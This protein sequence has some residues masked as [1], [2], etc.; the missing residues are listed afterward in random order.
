MSKHLKFVH[1]NFLINILLNEHHLVFLITYFLSLVIF[2]TM[3][4]SKC[5]N[6][7]K[8]PHPECDYQGTKF[9]L[10]QHFGRYPK[11]HKFFTMDIKT[12]VKKA[13]FTSYKSKLSFVKE[14]V[15]TSICN[16]SNDKISKME[17]YF[18]DD[19]FGNMVASDGH[20]NN[21]EL[22]NNDFLEQSN[23][24][25]GSNDNNDMIITNN[26]N[27]EKL[28]NTIPHQH[29]QRND[30]HCSPPLKY[31][32]LNDD[33]PSL[34]Y[35]QFCYLKSDVHELKLLQIL[36]VDNV[37]HDLHKDIVDWAR[38]AYNDGYKFNPK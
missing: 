4:R 13:A 14:Q 23:D 8:C 12:S 11:C 19:G 33:N 2:V 20:G 15:I 32:F 29:N 30:N 31:T 3:M 21:L 28:I 7:L 22:L 27:E 26:T 37:P 10:Q 36:S 18:E 9:R 25:N 34:I 16:T 38:E 1:H 24:N 6:G 5:H 35:K 17:M